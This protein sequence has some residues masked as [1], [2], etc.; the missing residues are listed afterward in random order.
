MSM[1]FSYSGIVTITLTYLKKHQAPNPK[2]QGSSNLQS[3]KMH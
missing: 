2:H 3:F 1:I